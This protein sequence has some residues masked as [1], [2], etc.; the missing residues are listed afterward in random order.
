VKEAKER[1]EIYDRLD[2]ALE[3]SGI[4][5][6]MMQDGMKR[7]VD[8]LALTGKALGAEIRLSDADYLPM[9]NRRPY[10]LCSRSEQWR[11]QLAIED[12][13]AFLAHVPYLVIDEASVLDYDLRSAFGGYLVGMG[14]DYEKIF[15]F[16][17]ETD[18]AQTPID[19]PDIQLWRVESG[20]VKPI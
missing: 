15:V 4:R 5:S 11:M 2:G 12:A 20:K 8:R 6:A 14:D 16:V 10:Q 7:F 19:H 13:I 9:F 1:I 3:P 17:T 18:H